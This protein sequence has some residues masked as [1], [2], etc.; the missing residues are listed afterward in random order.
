MIS[1]LLPSRRRPEKLKQSVT[2]LLETAENPVN[3]EILIRMDEDD[4]E[5]V[6]LPH[7]FVEYAGDGTCKIVGARVTW[8]YGPRYGYKE[9]H[10]YYN[11][12]ADKARGEWLMVWNDDA[13]M[14]Q[15]G[16]DTVL[17]SV[18]PGMK[19][20]AMDK[21]ALF[22]VVHRSVFECLGHLSLNAHTDSWL[23][24]VAR[25]AGV[26]QDVPV[27]WVHDRTN[28]QTQI[29][30]QQAMRTTQPDFFREPCQRLIDADAKKILEAL[31][32]AA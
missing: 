28:D 15:K 1:V 7:K 22:P 6:E 8:I 31:A 10:R 9:L 26:L 5:Y 14:E 12:L 29:E 27:K 19:V 20:L 13:M 16:W 3:I 21:W 30:A 24:A 2:R 4:H 23:D 11:E 25:R 17:E 18:E 32:K